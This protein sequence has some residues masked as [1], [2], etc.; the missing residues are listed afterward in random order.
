MKKFLPFLVIPM[1]LISSA[2]YA[3]KLKY[4]DIF[5]LLNAKKYEEAEPFLKK[6]LNEAKDGE[7]P[8]AYLFMAKVY[9]EKWKK[10]DYLKQ[11]DIMT[12][13]M[14]SALH[15]YKKSSEYI[16]D[17][18]IKKNSDFYEEYNR[19]D[20]R[21]GKFEIKLSEIELNIEQRVEAIQKAKRLVVQ[22]NK[23][24][25]RSIRNYKAANEEFKSLQ[26]SFEEER[27]FYLRADNEVL[28]KIKS[29]GSR[30][31][32]CVINFNEYKRLAKDLGKIG[33][34]HELKLEE[35][36]DFK[37]DGTSMVDFYENDLKLW[38]Y[39]KWA[40]VN[41]EAIA[42]NVM[43]IK[44]H[45]VDFDIEINKLYEKFKADSTSV[46]SD[47]TG[48]VDR[49]LNGAL[50]RF[51]PDP[52]P[53]DIFA[54]KI[55]EL[56]YHSGKIEGQ[57]G[58]DSKTLVDRLKLYQEDL[59]R[60]KRFHEAS[61]K[62]NAR[63]IEAEYLNYKNFIDQT[64]ANVAA[65]KAF[66]RAKEEY[67]L[68]VLDKTEK[69]FKHV[70]AGLKWIVV[71]KD[72]IPLDESIAITGIKPFIIEAERY[73]AGVNYTKGSTAYF[74]I[75]NAQRKPEAF[76]ETKLSA[77]FNIEN[78]SSTG[79]IGF[80]DP[81]GQ[82][83]FIAFFVESPKD[84]KVTVNVMKIYRTDGLSWSI[85]TELPNK[86]FGINYKTDT[87]EL[88]LHYGFSAESPSVLVLDKNGKKKT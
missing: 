8:S 61:K 58:D 43:P 3:Q 66:A 75:I 86:P 37:R 1:M 77:K 39:K 73:T 21:T 6:Y 35:I 29:I 85:E 13:N 78:S 40:N 79:A 36:K 41:H 26:N 69:T 19:R 15:F 88:V 38:D 81:A 74:S 70:E 16:N 64:F 47:L 14:D 33:Y 63:N 5:V 48:L 44:K 49:I 12:M 84:A 59:D 50:K 82:L 28:A 34:N 62:L 18:E 22:M 9:D 10:F 7:Q 4:K 67:A 68:K 51:D 32:S 52:L 20:L 53:M 80:A 24:F 46:S 56:Q 23:H 72:S 17:K 57:A 25:E 45:L 30:A 2:L 42:E 60:A 83:F 65:L 71:N 54:V 11:S 55:A 76:T 87:G 27:I 31:D